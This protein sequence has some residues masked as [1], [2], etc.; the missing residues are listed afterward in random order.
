MNKKLYIKLKQTKE[1]IE[2]IKNMLNPS[3]VIPVQDNL[4]YIECLSDL[5]LKEL[6]KNLEQDFYIDIAVYEEEIVFNDELKNKILSIFIKR[7]SGY[8]YLKNLLIDELFNK[9]EELFNCLK[10]FF[11][12]KLT[13]EVIET[14]LGYIKCSNS[15]QASKELFIHRNTLNYRLET[16]K[17][18][19][20]LDLKK[21]EDKVIYYGLF[22]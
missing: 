19:T 5:D 11:K 9:D 16:I 2:C 12:L 20:S 15:I 17:K 14:G 3:L 10:S 7:N 22:K 8:Y 13:N 1:I 4:I 18:W 21:F 6:F